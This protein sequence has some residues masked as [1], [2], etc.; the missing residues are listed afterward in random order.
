MNIRPILTEPLDKDGYFSVPDKFT[1][2]D[3][4]RWAKRR[5]DSIRLAQYADSKCG[6][7]NTFDKDGAYLCGG[8]Q[9]GSSSPCNKLNGSECLI[10]QKVIDKPHRQSCEF[11]EITNA[12]DPEARYSPKG[13]LDDDRIAFG[14]TKN[15]EGFGCRRCEYGQQSMPSPDSEG[16][17]LWCKFKGHPVEGNAC[18]ADN[19]PI[20]LYTIKSATP[21]LLMGK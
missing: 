16:R 5:M 15:P 14:E 11:Y 13:K 18:C 3:E 7:P 8:R 17:S 6:L 2:E 19:D 4:V 12:G 9:D 10:R 20:K 1:S 21:L